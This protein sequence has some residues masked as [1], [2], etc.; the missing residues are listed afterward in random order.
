MSWL[1][2]SRRVSA[3]DAAGTPGLFT[4]GTHKHNLSALEEPLTR[5][6]HC[7]RRVTAGRRGTRCSAPP[8]PRPCGGP[9]ASAPSL[10]HSC[11]T[12]GWGVETLP[13]QFFYATLG[14]NSVSLRARR[15]SGTVFAS[16]WGW[17]GISELSIGVSVMVLTHQVQVLQICNNKKLLKSLQPSILAFPQKTNKTKINTFSKG[18]KANAGPPNNQSDAGMLMTSHQNF[19]G[20]IS[21]TFCKSEAN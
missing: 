12:E 15:H 6:T 1:W 5:W 18:E 17:T 21:T 16:M 8:G 10:R 4:T 3:G 19:P 13:T 11:G 20:S 7:C 9:P 2:F 14:F